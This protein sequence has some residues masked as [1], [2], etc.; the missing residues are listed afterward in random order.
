MDPLVSRY[1]L[2][3]SPVQRDTVCAAKPLAQDAPALGKAQR[4]SADSDPS[5]AAA[6]ALE[7]SAANDTPVVGA[8][9]VTGAGS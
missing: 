3:E 5:A 9:G 6:S 4:T 7:T 2:G 8:T 1:L